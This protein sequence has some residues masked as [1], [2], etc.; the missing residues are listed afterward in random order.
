MSRDNGWREICAC[1]HNRMSFETACSMTST[2]RQA[3]L[4]TMAEMR[5]GNVDWQTGE[6]TFDESAVVLNDDH[7]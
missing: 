6:V 5:G 2:A 7:E 4:L 1:V 3:F